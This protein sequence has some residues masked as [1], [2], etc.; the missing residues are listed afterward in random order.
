[1]SQPYV[2]DLCDFVERVWEIYR[3]HATDF[4]SVRHGSR[5]YLI[6]RMM[7]IAEATSTGIRLNATWGL[8]SPAM[9]LLRDR[10]E[11]AVRFS[12]LVRNPD[13]EV[14]VKYE[15][16][17]FGK[18]NSLVRNVDPETVSRF[19]EKLGRAPSWA[20]EPLSKEERAYFGAWTNTDL[21]SMALKRDAFPPITD[22]PLAMRGLA[23]WYTSVYAQ[24]SSVSHYDRY[25]IELVKP[26]EQEDGTVALSMEP[27]WLALLILYDAYLDMIQC[28]EV[29][30]VCFK[31]QTSI[32][33]ESLFLEWFSLSK[34]LKID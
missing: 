6:V 7:Y 25:S 13:D 5:D 3:E 23:S 12:W 33:F 8:I 15:R 18:I 30:Q 1:M 19:E 34:Q 24:L 16:A 2:A 9:S 14:F 28:S 22:T 4:G 29:T 21:R 10:Y 27:H 31:Q 11:Q 26:I 32:K 20:T 17:F